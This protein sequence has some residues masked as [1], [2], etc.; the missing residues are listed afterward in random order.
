ML[1]Y[2]MLLI[3]FSLSTSAQE[4]KAKP[5]T[6]KASPEATALLEYF[7]SISGKHILSGQHNFPISGERNSQFA[8]DFI[9]KTPVV[10]SQDFGFSEDGDK[11]SYLARPPLL[12]RVIKGQ[13]TW[14]LEKRGKQ[15]KIVQLVD[16]PRGK[17]ESI[18]V[19]DKL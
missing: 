15:L 17:R 1:S 10:W 11:D 14:T 3:L 13:D 5:V 2:S 19:Y 7:Y 8:A 16:S 4:K 6:H 18:M 12:K 9:G